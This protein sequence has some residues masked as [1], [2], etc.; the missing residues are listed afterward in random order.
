M[1]IRIQFLIVTFLKIAYSKRMNDILGH[2]FSV[3][4]FMFMS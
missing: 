4:G 3:Y 2:H 1:L